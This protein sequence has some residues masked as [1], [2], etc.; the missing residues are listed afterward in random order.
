M[1]KKENVDQVKSSHE[2][3]TCIGLKK[4]WGRVDRLSWNK[5]SLRIEHVLGW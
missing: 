5:I 1:G 3:Y 2:L 4:G